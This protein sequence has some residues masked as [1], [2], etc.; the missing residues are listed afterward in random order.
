MIQALGR[1][2]SDPED[3]A[4]AM[5]LQK[6]MVEAGAS[7]ENIAKV[8]REMAS[9]AKGSLTPTAATV[10]ALVTA[11][12]TGGIEYDDVVKALNFDKVNFFVFLVFIVCKMFIVLPGCGRGRRRRQR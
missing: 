10:G 12:V 7:P 2:G 11:I 5:L 1:C 4:R 8:S 9:R 6:A 3:V